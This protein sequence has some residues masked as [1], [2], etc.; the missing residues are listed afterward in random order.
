MARNRHQN[1]NK[2]VAGTPKKRNM[3]SATGLIVDKEEQVVRIRNTPICWGIPMDE[4]CYS[5]FWV[6]FARSSNAMPWDGFITTESTYLPDARN[7]IHDNYLEQSDL[8]LLMM[9]DSDILFPPNMV[10]TLMKYNLPI[11]GGWYRNKKE[12]HPVV[13]DFASQ[14]DDGVNN[15]RHRKV[16]GSGVEKVDG[17]GAGCWLMRRKTAE[18]LGKSPYSMEAGGEDLWI[19]KKLMDLNIPL[20]VDW[21][22]K[23][24]HIGV[25]F[26]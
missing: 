18:K 5:K 1:I 25:F 20:H 9:L 24:A 14:S 3:A 11:V 6:N 22:M 26:V 4:V 19:C 8:P 12:N 2:I 16:P 15:F 13:Y 7:T 21:S 10:D 17:M 23:L